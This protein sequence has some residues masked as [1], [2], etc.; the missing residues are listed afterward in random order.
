MRK[1]ELLVSDPHAFFLSS[2]AGYLPQNVPLQMI[3]YLSQETE[4]LPWHAAS[5]ALYQLDKLLDRTEDHSLF[6]VS[7]ISDQFA[8]CCI[9]TLTSAIIKTRLISSS[10]S[11]MTR[12]TARQIELKTSSDHHPKQQSKIFPDTMPVCC[13]N[14]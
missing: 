13:S 8:V 1:N 14:L 10:T 12:L 9:L 5:R 6:S 11:Q 7:L 4:F 3:S 2:R